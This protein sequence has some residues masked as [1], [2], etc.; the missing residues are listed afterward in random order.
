[1]EKALIKAFPSTSLHYPTGP[2][3]L[4]PSDIPD[5][6]PSDSSTDSLEDL[7]A[8]AWWRRQEGTAIYQGI[9][10]GLASIADVIKKEGP[11]DG[12]I[13]FSQGGAAAAIVASLLEPTR[14]RSMDEIVANHGEKFPY[15]SSFLKESGGI[16]QPP[17]KFAI[18][19]SGFVAPPELY[20][21]FYEPKIK[22]PVLNYIGSFDTVVEES[23]TDELI[24][25]I[26]GG[27][28]FVVV[29]HGGH[30]V[31]TMKKWLNPA[32]GFIDRCMKGVDRVDIHDI[33]LSVKD[34][35]VPF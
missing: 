35:V 20:S 28:D 34:M 8:F 15:Q 2:I 6:T 26:E 11:F 29:H 30:F 33:V 32:L 22:T 31:P 23:R 3:A 18:V 19:Y 17:M 13:G 4:Q 21:G 7:Q 27:K 24:G 1:M 25:A 10:L 9:E 16:I 14:R 12:V 5:Y